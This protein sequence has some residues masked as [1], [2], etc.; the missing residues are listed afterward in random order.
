MPLTRDHLSVI[1]AVTPDG[2]LYMK[3]QDCAFKGPAPAILQFLRHLLHHIPYKLLIIW[4]GLPAHRSHAVKT[5][6]S[7]GTARRIH[8]ERLPSY[9]QTSTQTKASGA[10]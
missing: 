5:F 6:L 3:V 2:K 9:A 8:S 4:D 1:S 10:T 7:Q